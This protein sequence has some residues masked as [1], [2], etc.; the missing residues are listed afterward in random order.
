MLGAVRR[1][2]W[3]SEENVR[4]FG[5]ACPAEFF[6]DV[7]EPLADSFDPAQAAAY[8]QLM[9]AWIPPASSATPA[10]PARVEA[11]YVLSRVTL[12]SD[13][14]IVSPILSSMKERFPNARIVFVA[15]R[16]SAELFETDP[17]IEHLSADYPRTGPVSVR[18]S[19]AHELRSRLAAENCIVVDPDSRM[20]QLGLIPVCE[21]ERYFHFPSRT[22]GGTDGGNLSDLVRQ[23]LR[24]NFGIDAPAYIAPR[25]ERRP[26]A[27]QHAAVSLG[28]GENDSKRI[29]G[30]FETRLVEVLGTRYETIWVDRGVGGEEARRVTAAME[31]SCVSGRVRYWEGGFAGFASIISQCD[32]YVG[33][34]SAG[35]HAAAAAGVPLI[36]IFA[37]APSKRFRQRWAADGHRQID[38][39]VA[40]GLCPDDVLNELITLMPLE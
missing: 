38:C 7:V 10:I 11:V 32:M 17:R 39:V 34:D 18:V 26:G 28:V 24:T 19:F 16:K 20:T 40:D 3:A 33:Y 1:G 31:A 13:I 8:E 35:Q 15:N 29:G 4:E 9:R 14:K 23:W 37:G 30:D 2:V 25:P 6:R 12:G 5:E 21:P 22:I 36:S 27:G